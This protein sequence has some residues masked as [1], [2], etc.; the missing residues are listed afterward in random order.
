MGATKQEKTKKSFSRRTGCTGQTN[1]PKKKNKKQKNKKQ[2][3]KQK[4]NDGGLVLCK[5]GSK[6]QKTKNAPCFN[7]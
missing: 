5:N 6:K 7:I 2:K 3:E 4:K 1:Q